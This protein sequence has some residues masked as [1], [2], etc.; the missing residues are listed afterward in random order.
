M[1]HEG[2]KAGV[3][4]R[5]ALKGMGAVALLGAAGCDGDGGDGPTGE[6][7]DFELLRQRIDTVVFVMM[8]NRSFDHFLGALTLD[9]GRDDV[10]GL[11]L[12]HTNPHPDGYDV[13]PFKSAIHCL[14]DP[15]HSWTASHAQFKNGSNGGFVEVFHARDP[16]VAHEAMGYWTRAELPAYY[17]LSD[18]FV[19]CDHWFS[20]V[21]SSTWPNRFYA[22]SA[23]NGGMHGNDHS[24]E[25]FPSIATALREKGI[26]WANYFAS[27]P[28]SLFLWDVYLADDE[29]LPIERFFEHAEA[30]TLPNVVM[31]D[32][33]YGIA[34]DHPPAHPLAGQVFVASIYEA[35][36]ASPQ[37]DRTLLI[38][39]YDEHG[40]FHDHVPPPT[41]DADARASEGFDQLGFRV[42]TIVA[43]PYVKERHV[44]QVVYEHT[45]WLALIEGIFELDPLTARDAA[46]DPMF[47][48]FDEEALRSGQPRP[49]MALPIIEA[50]EDEIYAPECQYLRRSGQRIRMHQPELEAYIDA[51]FAGSPWDRRDEAMQ[52]WE[53]IVQRAADRGIVKIRE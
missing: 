29:L 33:V 35:L 41:T 39:T 40:G 4:R 15:P 3:D 22:T 46:A 52:I 11:T 2:S 42:P 27:A 37:W 9:E 7:I 26:P 19:V 5:T 1:S 17:T 30:G 25:G 32:P 34:D 21:M 16:E 48:V 49:P 53:G 12:D 6:G 44:S 47:D 51:H 24:E 36:A 28:F 10:E 31:V 8:E 20:S 23:Q 45:S 38:I 18:H 13:A 50:D 43:G 14:E